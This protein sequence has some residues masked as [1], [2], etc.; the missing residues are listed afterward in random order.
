[1][2]TL[3]IITIAVFIG[4][5]A[6][7]AWAGMALATWRAADPMGRIAKLQNGK[8]TDLVTASFLKPEMLQEGTESFRDL[9]RSFGLNPQIFANW[10]QQAE[11]PVTTRWVWLAAG[12]CSLVLVVVAHLLHAPIS[13]L[14]L[15]GLVGAGVPLFYVMWR[16]KRR[17]KAFNSQLP[18]ALELMASA[19]RSGNTLQASLQIIVEEM[20]PPLSKEFGI[21]SEATKLG[22]PVEQALDD[23]TRRLP[24]PDLQFFVTAVAMQRSTGGDLAEILDKI[25]WLVRERF[26]IQ[27]QVQAL[28]GEGRMSGLVLMALPILLFIVVYAL[29]PGYVMLLFTEPL[30]QKMLGGAIVLQVLGAIAIRR[31]VNIKI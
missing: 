25:S 27:G 6:V 2:T 12:I 28:T 20:L 3:A 9:L 5:A 31:I 21:V 17:I 29:N 16:R 7:C 1:M 10:L 11:L 13:T 18:D 4:T 8:P 15:V 26:Y 30:G 22:V 24:N 19:L 14:P 23:L